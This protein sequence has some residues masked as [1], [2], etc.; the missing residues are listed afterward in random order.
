MGQSLQHLENV[1]SQL[2]SRVRATMKQS[3]LRLSRGWVARN[4]GV[5]GNAVIPAPAGPDDLP[6]EATR[7]VDR[8]IAGLLYYP[9]NR[10]TGPQEAS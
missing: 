9:Q 7:N 2:D 3:L 6:S 5:E 8:C 4:P 10:M 1:A